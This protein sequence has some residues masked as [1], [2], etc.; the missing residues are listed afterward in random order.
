MSKNHRKTLI[1]KLVHN[2]NFLENVS[3]S[4]T[5]DPVWQEKYNCFAEVLP[6]SDCK[7]MPIEGFS[8]GN[9]ITEEYYLFKV[10]Y[11]DGLNKNLRI[12]FCRKLYSIKR[13]INIG[14]RNKI[15]NII[16]HEIL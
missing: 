12:S 1:A 14:Q 3:E 16:A 4:A 7:Y 10:R 8:F 9:F 15:L 5:N 13:I 2:I 11:M 6:L